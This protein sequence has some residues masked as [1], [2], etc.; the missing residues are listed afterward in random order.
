MEKSIFSTEGSKELLLHTNHPRFLTELL[1]IGVERALESLWK[2]LIV[3][4][5]SHGNE[6]P[7]SDV[8]A[9]L[10]NP[11]TNG[12]VCALLGVES[13]IPEEVLEE[14]ATWVGKSEVVTIEELFEQ[15]F[16]SKLS[17]RTG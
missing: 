17:Q 4:N 1:R 15:V 2:I 9:Y 7:S 16:A 13:V 6:I 14:A 5:Y 12:A 8:T 11:A 10:R 3:S